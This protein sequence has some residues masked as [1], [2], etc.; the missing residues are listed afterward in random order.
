MGQFGPSLL[1]LRIITSTSLK[2]ASA[3]MTG[4]SVGILVGSVVLGI[5]FDKMKQ[6]KTY[7]V[8]W[9]VLTMMFILAVIPWCY[10]YELMVAMHVFKGL[11]GGGLDTSK[12]SHF[13]DITK[14]NLKR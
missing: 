3:F 2:Q 1:D 12:Y 5:I 11:A 9:T 10:I 8:A 4:H 14:C 6:E 13:S 7:C